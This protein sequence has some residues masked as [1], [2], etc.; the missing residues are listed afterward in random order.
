[1]QQRLNFHPARL[2]FNVELR[3]NVSDC[4]KFVW[5]IFSDMGSESP[6]NNLIIGISLALS[7]MAHRIGT[8]LKRFRLMNPPPPGSHCHVVN[9]N[10]CMVD[11]RWISDQLYPY[12]SIMCETTVMNRSSIS[13]RK[14]HELDDD[15]RLFEGIL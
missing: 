14:H 5:H 3:D 7:F 1:M 12:G 13:N 2:T 6:T 9:H 8:F 15:R 4:A 11:K 10:M